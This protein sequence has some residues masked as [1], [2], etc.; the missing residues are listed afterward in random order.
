VFN[1]AM[2]AIAATADPAKTAP[3]RDRFATGAFNA[4]AITHPIYVLRV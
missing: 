3:F 1:S 2:P 4:F